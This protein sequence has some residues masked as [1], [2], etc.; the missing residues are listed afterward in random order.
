MQHD[1]I[2]ITGRLRFKLFNEAGAIISD[3]EGPNL[4]V[5]VGK[6]QLAAIMAGS[7]TA[8]PVA[9]AVGT[10]GTA[11]ALSDTALGGELARVAFS[12]ATSSANQT[13]YVANFNAGVGTGTILEAG[14]FS[15]TTSGAGILTSRSTSL[16]VTKGST[17]TLQITWTLYF[18]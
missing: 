16:S 10:S 5:Q 7:S 11:P 8:V 9:M 14:L 4:V 3:Q 12:S 15:S 17:D 18:N 6:N 2:S 1:N 13:T